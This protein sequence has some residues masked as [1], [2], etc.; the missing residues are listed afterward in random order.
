ML[1]RW[2]EFSTLFGKLSDRV[3]FDSKSYFFRQYIRFF[4]RNFIA[5]KQISPFVEFVNAHPRRID[6]FS[7]HL[8][9]AHWVV[10]K[11]FL[12]KKFS[13]EQR[14]LCIEYNLE[15]LEQILSDSLFYRLLQGEEIEILELEWGL[16]CILTLNGAFEEGFLAIRLLYENQT[17]YHLSFGFIRG[18]EAPSLLIACVQGGGNGD[19]VRNQIKEVTKKLFGLRPQIFLIE[20]ARFFSSFIKSN[21]LLGVQQDRQ[22]RHLSFGKRKYSMDYDLMWEECGGKREGEYFDLTESKQKDLS[23]IPSQKRSMYKKR[24]ALLDELKAQ[25]EQN[26]REMGLRECL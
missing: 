18:R 9:Q 21:A 3:G 11:D 12:N 22:V 23:E 24:F 13:Q 1:Y 19:E 26:F 6:L 5:R 16:K 25:M 14:R 2:P 17:I 7:K 10:C 8:G 20:I 4:L 15:V